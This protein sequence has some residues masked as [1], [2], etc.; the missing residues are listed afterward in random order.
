MPIRLEYQIAATGEAQLKSVFRGIEAEAAKMARREAASDRARARS[1]VQLSKQSARA[2]VS[3]TKRSDSEQTRLLRQQERAAEQSAKRIANTRVREERRVQQEQARAD[4]WRQGM[5]NRHFQQV[6][7]DTRRAERSMTRTHGNIAK[8]V[9]RSVTGAAGFVGG[10]LRTAA[11]MAGLGAGFLAAGSVE[12]QASLHT[13]AANL[14]NQAYDPSKATTRQEIKDRTLGLAKKVG[15]DSALG[16]G[17]VLDALANFQMV[18]GRLDI[19]EKLAGKMSEYANATGADMGDVG[20]SGGQIVQ[21]LQARGD[22]SDLEI[23]SETEAILASMAGQTKKGSIEFADLAQQMGAVMASTAG[24]KGKVSDLAETMGAVAQISPASGA[25][26][27]EEAM[28]AIMNFRNELMGN[29]H[30]FAKVAEKGGVDVFTDKT[31]TQVKDP[32]LIV[33]E[34]LKV[35]KGDLSKVSTLFGIR[36]QKA[37]QPFQEAFR[38]AGGAE[39]PEK[40]IAGMMKILNNIRGSRM[41]ED[42]RTQSAEF[43]V[44]QP[45]A[46]FRQS[47]DDIQEE[48]GSALLPELKKLSPI[49]RDAAPGLGKLAENAV[50]LAEWLGENP[51]EGIGILIAGF[52]A[53]DIAIA[54]IGAAVSKAVALAMS[55]GG[56]A[57]ASGGAAVAAGGTA[58]VLGLGAAALASVGTAAYLGNELHTSVQA[59][60]PNKGFLD[61]LF[62]IIGNGS[63]Q[64]EE[65][66]AL[67]AERRQRSAKSNY[68]GAERYAAPS[69]GGSGFFV[70]PQAT[71]APT[72]AGFADPAT[73]AAQAE[74]MKAAA[75]SKSA[76]D[77]YLAA[78]VQMDAVVTKLDGIAAPNRTTPLRDR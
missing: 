8:G 23:I 5:R 47:M 11:G 18:S 24:F 73:Q 64:Q 25:T 21:N 49:I 74:Q 72:S 68:L 15:H 69:G 4:K 62:T 35:T 66:D 63:K 56:T 78:A 57:L 70:D 38:A 1:R 26:S 46:Q 53:K 61:N 22:L 52:I 51:Y 58:A 30:L 19:G 6:E 34:I 33:A 45:G 20:R 27:P 7:R 75:V 77:T 32:M 59:E 36:A 60:D 48:I 42:E 17:P 67:E 14:A 29:S 76:A 55:G 13:K 10:G 40:G 9:G 28:T 65:A 43:A 50:K 41:T 2:D 44:S 12:K 54:G 37:V 3:T 31:K 16:A 71:S 39:D